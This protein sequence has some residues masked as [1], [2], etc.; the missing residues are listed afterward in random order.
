MA[1]NRES[2]RMSVMDF[3]PPPPY[4]EERDSM[5]LTP[6]VSPTLK[7]KSL[8]SPLVSTDGVGRSGWGLMSGSSS[9]KEK[10][11]LDDETRAM[12]LTVANLN[13]ATLNARLQASDTKFARVIIQLM[14]PKLEEGHLSYLEGSG[15]GYT[16]YQDDVRPSPPSGCRN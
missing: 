8:V 12:T 4:V 16:F 6:P 10:P 15:W 2:V 13:A 14:A 7:S 11:M 1:K 5:Q 3:P 9:Q